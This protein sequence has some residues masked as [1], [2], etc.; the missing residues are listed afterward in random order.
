MLAFV[1]IVTSLPEEENSYGNS[2]CSKLE[3]DGALPSTG[4][5]PTAV[6]HQY[7]TQS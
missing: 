1:S 5:K 4:I 6:Q 3:T 7:N 2:F